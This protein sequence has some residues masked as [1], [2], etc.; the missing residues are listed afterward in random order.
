MCNKSSFNGEIREIPGISVD[1]FTGK[2][3][4]SRAF[5]IS[6]YHM[7]HVVGLWLSPLIDHLR[8]TNAYIYTTEITKS[9]MKLEGGSQTLMNYVKTLSKGYNL[10]T[11][12]SVPEQD[13][14]E[15]LVD[16]TLIPAGHSLGSTMFLFKIP[17]K[18]V[19]YTGDF[20]I[21]INDVAK[22][23]KL[24]EPNGEPIKIDALYVDT[25]FVASRFGD[26]PKRSDTVESV[27]DVIE[28]WLGGGPSREVAVYL[29]GNYTFE[30]IFN[31][32]HERLK[33]K[34]QVGELKWRLYS[35]IQELVPGVTDWRSRVHLCPW[36]RA[37]SESKRCAHDATLDYLHVRLSAYKWSDYD[38]DR[39][40]VKR[41]SERQLLACFSTHCSRSELLHFVE[42]LSPAKIVG[43]PNVYTPGTPP[44][45][46]VAGYPPAP[47]R[48]RNRRLDSTGSV[49]GEI[50]K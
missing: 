8:K 37:S 30:F 45:D 47:K 40:P 4:S 41:E 42:H 23:S 31:R 32:I 48:R 20:R 3:L 50:L 35:T 1:N 43:F 16:V 17:E 12:P 28:T 9:I 15:M 26:F 2:N 49:G 19:L 36:R 6:H 33:M 21:R 10:I 13:L 22:Y 38:L 14:E 44:D 18:T 29:P 25:T 24:H 27:I 7:D 46:P 34:V 11:L 39:A 5:F